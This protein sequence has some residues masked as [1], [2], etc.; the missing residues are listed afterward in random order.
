MP[1]RVI[2]LSRLLPGP[3][4]TKKLAELGFEVTTVELP[5]LPDPLACE[6][7]LHEG[8][9]RLVL[10]YRKPEGLARLKELVAGG[11]VLIDSFRPGTLERMGLG[12]PELQ[13]L[14]PKLVAC[15]IVAY[16]DSRRAAHDLNILAETGWLSL[17]PALPPTQV[18]DLAAAELALRK[19]LAA[20]LQG[21]GRRVTVTMREALEDWYPLARIAKSREKMWW[22]G[23]DPFYRLYRT[24]DG[25]HVAVGA[26]EPAFQS[27]LLAFLG[28]AD[29]S[30]LEAAFAARTTAEWEKALE[31]T[32]F[33]VS[34]VRDWETVSRVAA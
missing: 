10:E 16:P 8:K 2:D 24:K 34:A 22:L 7:L 5:R 27:A 28:L 11:D 6:P 1:T 18:A 25:G 32:D 13:A 12:W 33:C 14:N 21:G 9:R 23:G 26:V 29:K 20:L 4:A 15:S 17:S 30:G 3:W 31:G 19:I